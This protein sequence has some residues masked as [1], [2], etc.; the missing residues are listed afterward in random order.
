MFVFNVDSLHVEKSSKE[1]MR[2]LLGCDFRMETQEA[3]CNVSSSGLLMIV[4][5]FHF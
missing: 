3:D 2:L 4:G 1:N 5:D